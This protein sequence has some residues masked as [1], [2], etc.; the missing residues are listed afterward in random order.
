VDANPNNHSAGG[1]DLIEINLIELVGSAPRPAEY[2]I[3]VF[4]SDINRFANASL[5]QSGL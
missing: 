1:S 4:A 2:G 5:F 3:D